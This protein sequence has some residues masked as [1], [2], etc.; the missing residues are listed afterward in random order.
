[1]PIYRPE[2]YTCIVDMLGRAGRLEDAEELMQQIPSGPSVWAL[3]SL[4]GACRMVA[5][6]LTETEPTES[7]A[8][9]L[10][11]NIYA[12]KGD[13]GAVARVRRQMR[14][15]FVKKEV[16]SVPAIPCTCTRYR[17]TT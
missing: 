6:F 17:R 9:V 14:E 2:H 10:L 5:G 13:W 4:L 15:R 11:S 3:Q 16:S 1:M 12:E 8:Y 7:G